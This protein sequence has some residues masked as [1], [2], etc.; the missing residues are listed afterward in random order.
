MH[1]KFQI[2]YQE[3]LTF[4]FYFMFYCFTVSVIPFPSLT[5]P[6]KHIFLWMALSIAEA[7]A[8]VAKGAKT[9]LANRTAICFNGP[10]S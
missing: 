10:A 7:D 8:I 6:L 4:F 9:Y 5:T 3:I 1:P 2:T